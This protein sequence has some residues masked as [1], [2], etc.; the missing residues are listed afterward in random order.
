MCGGGTFGATT[1][2]WP[3]IG[4]NPDGIAANG[5]KSIGLLAVEVVVVD[6]IGRDS[7]LRL[8]VVAA[9]VIG[10][11]VVIVPADVLWWIVD[12]WLGYNCSTIGKLC[13]CVELQRQAL[14]DDVS[15][16]CGGGAK[17]RLVDG[18]VE[19]DGSPKAEAVG[20]IDDAVDTVYGVVCT[21]CIWPIV[22]FV[23]LGDQTAHGKSPTKRS[24]TDGLASG[25]V[26]EVIFT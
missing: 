6:G 12:I 13:E 8:S 25:C 2:I 17:K 7:I 19:V 15:D 9:C 24:P 21:R 16:R 5:T 1:G 10:A 20:R 26:C 23:I 14:V 4:T 3:W 18:C 11:I 22:G